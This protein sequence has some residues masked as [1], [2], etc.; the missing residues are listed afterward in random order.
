MK[1]KLYVNL[2]LSLLAIAIAHGQVEFS[3][4]YEQD[5]DTLPKKIKKRFAGSEQL[6]AQFEIDALPGWQLT[7]LGGA[8]GRQLVMIESA[9]ADGAG[10]VYSFG[11]TGDAD[12]SLGSVSTGALSMAFGL[13]L[14]NKSGKVL[15]Q[16]DMFFDGE[17]WRNPHRTKN[18]LRFSYGLSG[19]GISTANYL[20]SPE[21]KPYK[22][23]DVSGENVGGEDSALDGKSDLNR[24]KIKGTLRNINWQ[25]DQILFLAWANRDDRGLGAGL[26][27]DNLTITSN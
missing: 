17:V 27:I 7:K 11:H 22:A 18:M 2:V 5:F 10:A 24:K 16:V 25:P 26:A 12:R 8:E 9:G 13:A 3:G 6:G 20:T 23:F 19:G 1:T 4:K 14:I 15:N 21:M